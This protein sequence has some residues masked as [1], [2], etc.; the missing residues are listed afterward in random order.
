MTHHQKILDI[1][2]DKEWHC[3]NEFRRVYVGEYRSRINELRKKQGYRIDAQRCAID[4]YHEGNIPNMWR[5]G[6]ISHSTLANFNETQRN[7]I[8]HVL[9]QQALFR[10]FSPIAH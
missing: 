6:E 10:H 1:L 4:H 7:D 2:S 8:N 3:G 9:K 5:I